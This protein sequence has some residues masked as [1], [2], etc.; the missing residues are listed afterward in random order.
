MRLPEDL[1][2]SLETVEGFNRK[3]FEEIHSAGEQVT[4][5]RINVKRETSN[6]NDNVKRETSNVKLG[7]ISDT[8][9]ILN[10]N[11]QPISRFTSHVSRLTIHNKVPWT[12]NGYY[13][14]ERPSFTFDPLF[15]AG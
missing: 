3:S 10:T 6:V 15:H 14:A 9:G 2:R 5:V 4:S 1:L 12:E 8:E 11:E 7:G 13:L